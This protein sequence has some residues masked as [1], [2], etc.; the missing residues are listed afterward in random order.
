[1]VFVPILQ[2][3]VPIFLS[4]RPDDPAPPEQPAKWSQQPEHLKGDDL[5]S[6]V[7]MGRVESGASEDWG[8]NGAADTEDDDG[9]EGEDRE[10]SVDSEAEFVCSH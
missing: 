1:M 3:P 10:S 5:N 6:H 9:G 7:E 2:L 4:G 8:L